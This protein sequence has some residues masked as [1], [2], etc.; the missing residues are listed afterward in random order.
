VKPATERARVVDPTARRPTQARPQVSARHRLGAGLVDMPRIAPQ[1][2]A[3]AILANPVIP[4]SLRFC[5]TDGTP[6]GRSENGRPGPA[7]GKCPRC[8]RPFSFSPK[9]AP[10]ELVGGQYEVVGCLAHGGLGWIYLARNRNVDDKP[11]VLKGLLNTGAGDAMETLIAE[12]RF[13]AAV[14]HPDIVDIIDFARHRADGYI[15]M[16]YVAGTS[17]RAVLDARRAENGDM[18]NPLPVAQALAYVHQIM[19]AVAYLHQLGLLYCDFKPD[20][21]MQTS[22]SLK[23]IDLGGVH[24]MG[25]QVSAVYGTAGYTAPE[26]GDGR[27]TVCSDLFAIGRTLAVLCTDSL[28]YDGPYEFMLRP[29]DEVLLYAR[30]D[31][32][33]RL[34]QRATAWDPRDRFQSADEMADQIYGVLREAAAHESGV[35]SRASSTR[36]TGEQRG[37]LE[38]PD[39]RALP[40][41][42]VAADDPA[43]AFLSVLSTTEG[44]ADDLLDALASAPEVTIEVEM[45]R[46]RVLA[47]AGRA[48]DAHDVLDGL[49]HE[50]WDWR[51]AWYEGYT[52]LLDGSPA[53]AFEWFD[54]VYRAAPGELAAKL[55]LAYCAELDEQWEA[56]GRWYDIVSATDAEF[57]SAAFGLARCCL[58]AGNR[59]GA[60]AAYDRV[61]DTSSAYVDAQV[62]RAGTMLRYGLPALAD[63]RDA[64]RVVE[65]IPVANEAYARL[66][67]AVL[68]AALALLIA[69]PVSTPENET[70]AVLGYAFEERAI[71]FGL[72][73]AYRALAKTARTRRHRIA[74]VERANHVRSLTIV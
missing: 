54:M 50:A 4:E 40:T 32:L 56:A 20:N 24:R 3:A 53:A 48:D 2:P 65:R 18:P 22:R 11:V 1:D 14:E 74:L 67:V 12:R 42:L 55:A 47:E 45:R 6:V 34:L 28:D 71:R 66:S 7:E 58:V 5:A 30:F 33:Y 49:S 9:L 68:E 46:A 73:Q 25:D 35:P 43:R 57:V 10:G 41:L 8:E 59:L 29:R 21:L 64:A 44:S 51:V 72:E 19:P 15:V 13:L 39:G 69:A 31:S 16:E 23:L 60:I 70:A 61:P 36:F 26:I 38:R 27:P 52:D 62:A 37:D 17:L 63:V